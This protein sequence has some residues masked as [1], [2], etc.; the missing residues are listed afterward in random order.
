M[1]GQISSIGGTHYKDKGI[2]FELSQPNS[3]SAQ[4][5]SDKVIGRTTH[6]LLIIYFDPIRRNMKKKI[7]DEILAQNRNL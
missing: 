1:G 7:D 4:V 3:T 2:S 6:S 5:G